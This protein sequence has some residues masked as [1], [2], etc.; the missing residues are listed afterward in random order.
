MAL[1][2]IGRFPYPWLGWDWWALMG[3]PPPSTPEKTALHTKSSQTAS[4]LAI[5]CEVLCKMPLNT[6]V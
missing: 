3:A 6:P 1:R 5:W 2:G 4:F